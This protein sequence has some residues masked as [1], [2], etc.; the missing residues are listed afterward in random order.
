MAVVS[1]VVHG[2][3]ILV[4]TRQSGTL[5]HVQR[6]GP[7]YNRVNLGIDDAARAAKTLKGIVGKRLTYRRTDKRPEA[8]A[9]G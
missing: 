6:R 8:P 2:Y 9:V 3:C 1:R 7:S 5:A 4:R